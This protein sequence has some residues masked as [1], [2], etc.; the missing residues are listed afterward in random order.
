M[1]LHTDLHKLLT[2]KKAE[3]DPPCTDPYLIF[4]CLAKSS[5]DSIGDSILSTVRKAAR[6]AV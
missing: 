1:G 6:L 3:V 2:L 4:C 5:A